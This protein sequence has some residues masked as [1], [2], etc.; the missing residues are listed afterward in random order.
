MKSLQ[1]VI[2]A[3]SL[4]MAGQVCALAVPVEAYVATPCLK[5]G[6]P[7]PWLEHPDLRGPRVC[8]PTTPHMDIGIMRPEPN[9]C[10]PP[11]VRPLKEQ[12]V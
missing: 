5:P 1:A 8:K 6:K 10:P 12:S 9:K 7:Y 4:C 3:L 11:C 2:T